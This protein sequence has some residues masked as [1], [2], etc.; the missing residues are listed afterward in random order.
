MALNAEQRDYLPDERRN[1]ILNLLTQHEVVTV[2]QLA[3]SLETTEIT[4]RRD[5]N[6]LARAGLLK[7]IRGGAMSIGTIKEPT[8][9]GNAAIPGPD[10]PENTSIGVMVPEPSFFWPGIVNHMKH[11]AAESGISL[12]IRTCSYDE[13][14]HEERILQELADDPRV[15][16]IIAAPNSHPH[17]G[18][19]AW[20]W[21][22]TTTIPTVVLEREQ[23]L[24][25][26]RYVDSVQTD[27][28]RGVCKAVSHFL[29]HG[30]THIGAT[31]SQTPTSAI[32][33]RSWQDIVEQ[34]PRIECPFVLTGMMP[35]DTAGVKTIVE[36][37]IRSDITALLVHSDYLAIAIA[38]A[39]ENQGKRIPDDIS[40]ISIDGFA[41]P[42]SRPLTVLRSD[43]EELAACAIHT[44]LSRIQSPDQPVHR[45]Y[46]DPT[47]IDRGS[48]VQ[49]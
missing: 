44:L 39:L 9:A 31:F 35:Y 21:I 4:V 6:A 30:H 48:V 47:L 38:Q 24:L 3:T 10:T 43:E 26:T 41:T 18:Q 42:S 27:H 2:T 13:N 14:M 22:E 7:R 25:T 49:R 28:R 46:L 16:G 1:M 23:P 40:L 33:Q 32:I 34:T 8:P 12:T 15:C 19:H 17:L 5:L 45:M 36:T 11:I 29:A 37:I 20:Q